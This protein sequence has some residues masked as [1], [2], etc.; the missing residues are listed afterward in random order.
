MPAN[1]RLLSPLKRFKYGEIVVSSGTER[2]SP[3]RVKL[4]I[5]RRRVWM[6]LKMKRTFVSTVAGLMNRLV[7]VGGVNGP[8]AA[9][10]LFDKAATP[11]STADHAARLVW[12]MENRPRAALLLGHALNRSNNFQSFVG[13]VSPLRAHWV[14][15]VRFTTVDFM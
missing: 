10:T 3:S 14:Q 6:P 9:P 2:R 4:V 15:L 1:E 11:E 7:V 5:A 12:L 13:C 8:V